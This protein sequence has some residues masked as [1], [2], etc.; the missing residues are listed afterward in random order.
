MRQPQLTHSYV[1]R[2][3][4]TNQGQRITVQ[5]LRTRESYE[6]KNWLELSRFMHLKENQENLNYDLQE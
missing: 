6:F 2:V 5:D 3:Q 4:H 1:V